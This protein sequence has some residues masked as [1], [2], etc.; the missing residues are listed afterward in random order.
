M[1]T[2]TCNECPLEVPITSAVCECGAPRP[3]VRHVGNAAEP[4]ERVPADEV[5]LCDHSKARPGSLACPDCGD[6]LARRDT[7]SIFILVF[8]WGRH[9]V[10]VGDELQLGAE[11]EPLCA[12]L[13]AW[14][15]VSARHATIRCTR[16]GQLLVTDQGSTN[17]TYHNGSKIEP[18]AAVEVTAGD[19]LAFSRRLVVRVE[20]AQ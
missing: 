14:S 16:R 3:A 10:G 13:R 18:Y 11:Q 19:E 1:E 7:A 9:G 6:P 15:T 20:G 4:P 8:P 17:G 12:N 2:V 5:T